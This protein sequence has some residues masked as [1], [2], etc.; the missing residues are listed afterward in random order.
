[1]NEMSQLASAMATLVFAAG[2]LIAAQL[3]IESRAVK[4]ASNPT[5]RTARS[6][7][8]EGLE[9]RTDL[10]LSRWPTPQLQQARLP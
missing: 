4:A 7:S 5:V 6:V 3:Y 1:M 10:R 9:L 8:G 2:M